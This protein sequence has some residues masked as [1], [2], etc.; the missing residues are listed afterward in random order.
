MFFHRP[1]GINYVDRGDISAYDYQAGDFIPDQTWRVLDLSHI[2]PIHTKQI[3]VRLTVQ[4]DLKD[5]VVYFRTYG[6]TGLY[7]L[8]VARTVVKAKKL[9][10]NLHIIPDAQRRI[11]YLAT[12]AEYEVLNFTIRGWYV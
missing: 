1:L 4:C 5:I 8:A 6:N 11:E 9:E 12:I 7:N 2:I 3:F 10:L